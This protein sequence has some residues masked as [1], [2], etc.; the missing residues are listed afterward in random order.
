[1]VARILV[2]L[3][4]LTPIIG[5]AQRYTVLEKTESSITL[6]IDFRNLISIRDTLFE[7][8]TFQYFQTTLPKVREE[9]EPWL[10]VYHL[11]AGVPFGSQP[12]IHVITAETETFQNINVLPAPKPEEDFPNLYEMRPRKEIYYKNSFFPENA[13]SVI[14]TQQMRYATVQPI[15]FNPYI[16][17][18]VTRALV[19]NKK[20]KVRLDFPEKVQDG[21][22]FQPHRDAQ[23]ENYL[24]TSVI[25]PDE[26]LLWQGEWKSLESNNPANSY[27]YNP[28]KYYLKIYVSKK[29]IYRVTYQDLLNAGAPIGGGVSSAKLELYHDGIENFLEV[30]DGGDSLFG[31]G[32]HVTFVGYPPKPH[33]PYTHLNTDVRYNVYWLSFQADTSGLR[34]KEVSGYPTFY[35]RTL[36]THKRTVHY[37]LDSLYEPL[38]WAPDGNRDYWYWGRASALN[39]QLQSIFVKPF[40]PFYQYN[41]NYPTATIRVNM[42]GLTTSNYLCNYDHNVDVYVNSKIVD[43]IKWNA[44]TAMTFVDSFYIHP[45]SFQVFP[46]NNF[47]QVRANGRVCNSS[48]SDEIR[49]NW[50]EFEYWAYNW[51]TTDHLYFTSPP[52]NFGTNRYI[53]WRWQ[54]T[55]MKVYV[56]LSGKLLIN[57]QINRDS[58]NSVL[59]ADNVFQETEYFCGTTNHFFTV[60]SIVA[61]VPS[62]LRDVNNAADYIVITHPKFQNIAQRL[63]NFRMNNFPDTTVTNPRIYIANVMDIYDE[64]SFGKLN[65]QSIKEFIKYAYEKWQKPSP[66][67]VVL[68]GDMSFDYRKINPNSRENYI[69]S[70]AYHSIQYGRAASDNGFVTVAGADNIPDLVI[71]RISI[72]TVAEGNAYLDKLEQ[73]PADPGKAWRETALLLASGADEVDE[74]KFGFNDESLVLYN[75]YLKPMG[76]EANMVFRFPTKPPHMPYKGTTTEIKKGFDDGAAIVN[77]YGHGG[78]YQWDLAFLEDDI[79]FL[80]NIGR[81]PFIVS[82]TC[83]TAHYDNQDVFGEQ[84]IKIPQKGAISFLG[85]S[86]LTHWQIGVYFNQ[87]LFQQIFNY[88]NYISGSSFSNAK[89]LMPDYS[90]YSNQIS[91]LTL[92]GEPL[93]K[94]ALP[95]KV[96]FSLSG[97]DL[98]LDPEF[99]LVGDS[100][101]IKLD[102]KNYGILTSDTVTVEFLFSSVDTTGSIREFRV[103]V[104]GNRDTLDFYWKPPVSGL[105]TVT[106]KINLKD[107]VDEYDYNDNTAQNLIA[108]FNLSDPSIITPFD[109]L[110]TSANSMLFTSGDIGYYIAKPLEYFFEIDTSVTFGSPV[111]KSPKVTGTDGMIRWQSPQLPNGSYFWRARIYDG[112]EYGRWSK[113]RTIALGGIDAVGFHIS[114]EQLRILDAE[115]VDYHPIKKVLVQNTDL[116]LPEPK[117]ETFLEKIDLTT[118]PYF[119]TV[120]T[121]ALVTD[122][123]YFYVGNYWYNVFLYNPSGK[124]ML[125]RV[126]TGYHG[127]TKGADYGPV[128]NFYEQIRGQMAYHSDGNI[129]I[130]YGDSVNLIRLNTQ[131]QTFDTIPVPAGLINFKTGTVSKGDFYLSS[132]SQYVYSVSHVDTA[133]DYKYKMRIY[134]PAL[135]WQLVGEKDFPN[136]QSYIGFASYFV[137][138]GH[139][140]PYESFSAGYM[141]RIRIDDGY[142]VKDWPTWIIPQA[143]QNQFSQWSYDWEHNRAYATV[144]RR[145]DTLKPAIY[146]FYGRYRDDQGKVTTPEIGPAQNWKSFNYSMIDQGSFGQYFA[147][148]FGFHNETRSWDTLA[149]GVTQSLDLGM[150]DADKYSKLKAEISMIDTSKIPGSPLELTEVHFDYDPWL[151]EIAIASPDFSFSPDSVLQGLP[152]TISLRVNNISQNSVADAKVSLFLNSADTAFYTT[153]VSI[154]GDSFLTISNAIPTH[155]LVFTNGVRALV[156]Y[157]GREFFTFNNIAQNK[158]YI[159][160]DTINPQFRITFDGE[161]IL[162]G[163]LISKKPKVLITLQDNSPLPLDT[164]YFTLIYDNIPVGFSRPDIR[165]E[166]SPYPNSEAR[167]IWEPTL[168]EGK[169]YLDVLAKDASNNF[170][171]TTFNR[172]VFYVYEDDDIDRMFNYPNPFKKDTYFT[173]ELRGQN[174]PEEIKIKVYTIAGRLIRDFSIPQSTYKIG[175]NYYHWDGKDQDGDTIANGLYF[176]KVIVKYKDRTKTFLEKLVKME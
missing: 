14:P 77:Y 105:I 17:N 80:Q 83:Y 133:G 96:D 6:E 141:R 66:N 108:V 38:G 143:L 112:T 54:D 60:D 5:F 159:S 120:G 169:H 73:Y 124:S 70:I 90:Y 3:V 30:V 137:T 109:G 28:Q 122:G 26:S 106:A 163:D 154:P 81:L 82:V 68:I 36:N 97:K 94:L 18:P 158:F 171:D 166:Y 98:K 130:P 155:A 132:D 47:M 173:Y 1:M 117:M 59:F 34:F 92:L 165:F 79:Y 107:Q 127:T 121:S 20:L 89:A 69:P 12:R 7:G 144:Y 8:R 65:P 35:N 9:G 62:T 71:G 147:T 126:G 10:P 67:Y 93:L 115:N 129:Y 57:N 99:P 40:D 160:R 140:Y 53:L 42:H 123:K 167:I 104:F 15:L 64:F 2:L 146:S 32:D 118:I 110:A 25:N 22:Y 61:D 91:L 58:I 24:R 170:F 168:G 27:W 138:G 135:N 19:F 75:Y 55:T 150:Y 157:P 139:F 56:P 16:Y 145:L 63:K 88:K 142:L 119:D 152:L 172:S 131:T 164:S 103:P 23:T 85:S 153:T 78:G 116:R 31:P 11:S 74:L 52:Q 4:F 156:E 95:S 175:F 101:H 114:K 21:K 134:D 41:E 46:E 87:L 48:R 72:E 161:E 37:E 111:V 128:P 136:I 39:G 29:G 113:P 100:V 43:S 102:M 50:F 149:V 162:N 49:I 45:D 151:P 33:T 51:T 174:F 125:Y 76:Y 44:Q 86:G 148:V 84:F 13:A 176:Y